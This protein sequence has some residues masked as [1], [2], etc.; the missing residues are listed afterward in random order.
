M[1][2]FFD[3]CVITYICLFESYLISGNSIDFRY[4][5]D[6]YKIICGSYPSCDLVKDVVLLRRLY[7]MDDL[8][9]FD[10]LFSEIA[11]EEI[12]RIKIEHKREQHID[13]VDRLLEHWQIVIEEQA[14][15]FSGKLNSI[16]SGFPS[17]MHNDC[18]QC[19]EAIEFNSDYFITGDKK[20]IKKCRAINE[21][22]VLRPREIPFLKKKRIT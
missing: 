16:F 20:F 13:L 4:D 15:S 6:F 9:H 8:A 14:L 7:Q 2:L 17:Q 12:A 1:R 3:S 19:S 22:K 5:K 21:I 11:L 18:L 10:W